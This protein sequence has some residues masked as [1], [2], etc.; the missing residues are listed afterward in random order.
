MFRRKHED[1]ICSKKLVQY[2]WS[3]CPTQM[4]QLGVK[5]RTQYGVSRQHCITEAITR[6][7]HPKSN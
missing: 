3:G 2:M 7:Y 5:A 4:T 6:L 1:E